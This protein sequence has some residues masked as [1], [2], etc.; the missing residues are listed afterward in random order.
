M[1]IHLSDD[2]KRFIDDQVR[3]GRYAS[4]TEAIEEA[5]R[6]LERNEPSDP[7]SE[8]IVDRSS[9]RRENLERLFETLDAMPTA[10]PADGLTNRDHDQILY[11]SK[12]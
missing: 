8:G 10:D 9:R 11:E 3:L 5:I 6:L 7:A 2:R 12:P 4:A 1:T